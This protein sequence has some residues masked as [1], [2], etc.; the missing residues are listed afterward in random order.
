MIQP[1]FP[2][3][4]A[5]CAAVAVIVMLFSGAPALAAGGDGAGG[6][7]DA[8]PR[9]GSAEFQEARK[10]IKKERYAEAIPLLQKAVTAQPGN[11]DFLTELAYASRKSG[12]TASAFR[13]YD[14][15]LSIDPEHV[16]AMNYLG[17]LYVQTGDVEKAEVLLQRIDDECFFTCEEYTTLKA[18]IEGGDP[19][20]Y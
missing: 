15:A 13:Y 20:A 8:Q 6:G 19:T 17:I 1:R 16:G 2:R 3:F 4:G 14:E 11:P 12:D 5:A 18:V 9:P 7:G 10:L